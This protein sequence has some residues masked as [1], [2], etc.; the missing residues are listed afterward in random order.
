M[1]SITVAWYFENEEKEF[2]L[3]SSIFA[4]FILNKKLKTSSI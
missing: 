2:P 3:S 4:T 1:N